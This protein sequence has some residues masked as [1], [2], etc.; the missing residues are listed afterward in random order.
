M[1][2]NTHLTALADWD[3]DEDEIETTSEYEGLYA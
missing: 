2:N 1:T 3:M